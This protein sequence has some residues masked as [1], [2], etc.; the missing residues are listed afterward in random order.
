[1]LGFAIGFGGLGVAVN[2]MI[3]DHYSLAAAIGTIPLPLA[4][5]VLLPYPWKSLQRH[6]NK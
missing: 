3:A 5:A 6:L 2:G 1:M 4:A